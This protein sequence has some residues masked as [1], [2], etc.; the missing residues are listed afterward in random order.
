MYR[1]RFHGHTFTLRGLT[2]FV[3]LARFERRAIRQLL[4]APALIV[5]FDEP[6]DG[7][8]SP[9]RVHGRFSSHSIQSFVGAAQRR[10]K[11]WPTGGGPARWPPAPRWAA[12]RW[13]LPQ[14]LPYD[15]RRDHVRPLGPRRP[16]PHWRRAIL[17]SRGCAKD[18]LCRMDERVPRTG[19]GARMPVPARHDEG[20]RDDAR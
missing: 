13:R 8:A 4:E 9:R 3:F 5:T 17:R 1:T 14:H 20:A 12:H 15:G 19:T 10:R 16:A 6:G 11:T 2:Q 7:G 18:R